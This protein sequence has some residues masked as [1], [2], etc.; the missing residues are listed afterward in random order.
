M[1]PLYIW[2]ISELIII[3]FKYSRR[4][5]KVI[6]NNSVPVLPTLFLFSYAKLFHIIIS[7]LS[8]TVLYTSEGRKIVW[9]A[10]GNVDYLGPK[11]MFLFVIAVATLG[12]FLLPYTLILFLGLW[13]HMCDSGLIAKFLF[14]IKP[15]LDFHYAPLKDKHCYWFGFLYLVRVAIL[16]ITS[17]ILVDH[18]SI[19]TI[20]ILASSI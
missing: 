2:S 15:F 1:F 20:S 16:L 18:F 17:F 5:A 12:F 14:S 19:V 3:L 10:D 11:R 9:S 7:A 13:L 8:Y 6:G 4:V